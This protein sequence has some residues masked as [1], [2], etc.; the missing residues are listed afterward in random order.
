M[1]RSDRRPEHQVTGITASTYVFVLCAALNS[2][3]LGYDEGVS[4]T[5]GS[6]VDD[7]FGLTELQREMF[8][9]SI[10]FWASKLIATDELWLD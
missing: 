4:T 10:N 9:A 2:C 8:T 1:E 6:L 3:N 7:A 5:V